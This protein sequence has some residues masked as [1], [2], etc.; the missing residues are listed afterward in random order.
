MARIEAGDIALHLQVGSQR[1]VPKSAVLAW[2]RGEQ[3]RRRTAPGQL[4]TDLDT[5]QAVGFALEAQAKNVE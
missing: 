5:W 1:R 3:T 2:H 4:G